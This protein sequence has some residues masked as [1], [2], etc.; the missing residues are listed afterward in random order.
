MLGKETDGLIASWMKRHA[1]RAL[2]SEL[3]RCPPL[4]RDQTKPTER[5]RCFF[6]LIMPRRTGHGIASRLSR[7]KIKCSICSSQFNTW[8]AQHCWA[9]CINRMFEQR[10]SIQ[11]LLCR[12]HGLSRYCS[13]SG[14]GPR[15]PM[16][17][18]F[19]SSSRLFAERK[20]FFGT[21]SQSI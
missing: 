19:S 4:L 13:T 1:G 14:F 10:A 8:D 11:S 20:L 7:A 18:F 16:A 2:L 5:W 12:T 21:S 17:G 15:L 9:S 3:Q 6:C